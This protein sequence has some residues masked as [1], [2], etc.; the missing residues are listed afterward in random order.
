M[1]LIFVEQ[2]DSTRKMSIEV[3]LLNYK[4]LKTA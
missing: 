4:R 1:E 3:Y 2:K